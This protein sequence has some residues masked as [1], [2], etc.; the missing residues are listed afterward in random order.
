MHACTVPAQIR[1]EEKQNSARGQAARQG[2]RLTRLSARH[3]GSALFEMLIFENFSSGKS[4][5]V[6]HRSLTTVISA[7]C[8][9]DGVWIQALIVGHVQG[10]ASSA[11]RDD[12]AE[13][14][15]EWILHRTHCPRR[16]YRGEFRRTDDA[17]IRTRRFC[18][19]AWPVAA[20]STELVWL[21]DSRIASATLYGLKS[22][23]IS[24]WFG[25]VF[26]LGSKGAL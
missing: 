23:G 10:P 13:T 12:V 19:Y 3:A 5:N 25:S 6:A 16:A 14:P 4:D 18:G 21:V 9:V 15:V 8:V 22:G 7:A 24:G 2:R 26:A 17:R 11:D 1:R 20:V